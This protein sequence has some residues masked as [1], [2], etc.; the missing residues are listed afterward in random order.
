M[1]SSLHSPVIESLENGTKSQFDQYFNLKSSYFSVF[2]RAFKFV[3]GCFIN[4]MNAK[5]KYSLHFQQ[6]ENPY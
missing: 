5:N 2:S 4:Y 3:D 6:E 1:V